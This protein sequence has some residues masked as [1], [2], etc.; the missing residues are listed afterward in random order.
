MGILSIQ[1]HVCFGHAG[2]SSAVFPMQLLGNDVWPVHTVQFSNHTG[3]GD[4]SGQVFTAD[5]ILKLAESIFK[6]NPYSNCEAILTGYMGDSTIGDAIINIV[7][8]AKKNN[9]K[10]KFFCDPVMGDR[11][12]GFFVREGI[13]EYFR[14]HVVKLADH[15]SPNHYELEYLTGGRE[16]L[17]YES[18][19][20]ACAG[21]FNENL[22]SVLVTSFIGSETPS[23]HMDILLVTPSEM[24]KVTTPILVSKN[25]KAI[26]GTGDLI[27]AL[28]LGY[29]LKTNS[30]MEAL[31]PCVSSTYGIIEESLRKNRY[32]LDIIGSQSQILKSNKNF[33]TSQ[34]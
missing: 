1:S 23:G 19:K 12:R 24:H 14:D 6:V 16:L 33:L 15:I 7:K 11:G 21:L 17:T 22:R 29:Y 34:C 10:I 31:S 5:N 4:W 28:F 3:Y 18:V 9:P 2:N 27:S 8:V 13:P 25:E 20:D 30:L 32:E 26:V